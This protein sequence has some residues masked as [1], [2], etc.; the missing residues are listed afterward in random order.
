MSSNQRKW[1]EADVKFLSQ[2]Y[3][4][5]PNA[6]IAAAIGT[7][8]CSVGSKAFRLGIKAPVKKPQY[9]RLKSSALR[10]M[11]L[12]SSKS[13]AALIS[14]VIRLGM[15]CISLPV[16]VKSGRRSVVRYGRS[17]G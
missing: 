12:P 6:D 7:T 15:G 1:T 14:L 4:R 5:I 13:P 16:M 8:V 9:R 17:H 2:N 10:L 3:G 11:A